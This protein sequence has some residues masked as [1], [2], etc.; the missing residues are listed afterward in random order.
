MLRWIVLALTAMAHG[1]E[2]AP[3]PLFTDHGILQQDTDAPIWGTAPPSATVSIAF[4]GQTVSA[5]ADG[6]GRWLARLRTPKAEPGQQGTELV[7]A[8]G[9]RAITLEDILVGEVWLGSGQSNM[10]SYLGWYPLSATEVPKAD[11]PDI[12]LYSPAG[13]A[14]HG[15][16]AKSHWSRCTPAIARAASAT[17]YFFSRDLHLA[18]KVPVGFVEMAYGGSAMA[19]WVEAEMLRDDPASAAAYDYWLKNIFPGINADRRRQLATWEAA[20]A[21]A[22]AKADADANGTEHAHAEPKLPPRPFAGPVEVTPEQ[23]VGQHFRTHIKPV[24]PFAF[25]GILWDQGE[26]GQGIAID[27]DA[28]FA[29][30]IHGWRRGFGRELPVIYCQMPKGGGWGPTLRYFDSN[31]AKLGPLAPLAALPEKVPAPGPVFAGFAKEADPFA[32]MLAQDATFMAVTRDLVDN[33]HP[34][35]KDEY[36]HRFFLTAMNTVYGEPVECFGPVM[37]SARRESGR[38]R[39]AF[40]HVGRGLAALGGKPLQ[41]FVVSGRGSKPAWATASIDGDTVLITAEGLDG[42]DRVSYAPG[43]RVMWANLFNQDGLPAYPMTLAVDGAISTP[44]AK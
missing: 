19:Q 20:V 4:R 31:T 16:Y 23:V 34:H 22:K 2:L 39:I 28:A 6:S 36:G 35:D 5:T 30:M 13:M 24:M 41:G 32:R 43:G 14:H 11:Y 9:E 8:S 17:G 25:R 27:Y 15:D 38:I 29:A 3:F 1:A 37:T 10:D 42:V 40:A 33:I 12:R 21:A 44:P 26:S 18:R 7:I